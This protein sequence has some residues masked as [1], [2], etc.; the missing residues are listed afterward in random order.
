MTKQL[1]TNITVDEWVD[2][3]E[4]GRYVHHVGNLR[5]QED[6]AA[7]RHCC[8]G[9]LLDIA[10][11]E[12]TVKKDNGNRHPGLMIC[13]QIGDSNHIPMDQRHLLGREIESALNFLLDDDDEHDDLHQLLVGVNDGSEEGYVPSIKALRQYQEEA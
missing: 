12:W 11:A 8:L 5:N 1:R 7:V 13:Q 3:L 9:V 2:A 4:S 10:G 6:P